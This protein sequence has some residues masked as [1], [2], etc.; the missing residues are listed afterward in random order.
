MTVILKIKRERNY[1]VAM[2]PNGKTVCGGEF[3]VGGVDG[4]DAIAVIQAA[5]GKADVIDAPL[6]DVEKKKG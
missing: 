4:T 1:Y 2:E 5:I 6:L 3:D